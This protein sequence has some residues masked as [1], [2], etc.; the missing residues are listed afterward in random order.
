LHEG[1]GPFSRNGVRV[2]V[3]VSDREV[4]HQAA[5]C[6]AEVQTAAFGSFAAATGAGVALNEIAIRGV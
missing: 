4:T 3:V 1:L 2:P 5:F 6:L